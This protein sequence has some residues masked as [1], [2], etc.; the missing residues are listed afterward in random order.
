MRSDCG[1]AAEQLNGEQNTMIVFRNIIESF[2]DDSIPAE[3]QVKYKSVLS[4]ICPFVLF[5]EGNRAG[6][7]GTDL[8]RSGR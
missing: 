6:D 7:K 1:R 4:D 8:K 5:P 2:F 3:L